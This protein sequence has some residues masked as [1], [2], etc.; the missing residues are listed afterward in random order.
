MNYKH[1]FG[2]VPSRRLG[3]SLG[4]DLVEHKTCNFNCIYCEAGTTTNLTN[5]REDYVSFE[6]IKKELDDYLCK[7]PELDYITFS[8]AGEPTLHKYLGQMISYIKEK[9][10]KYK[11][12]L[13]TNSALFG[14]EDLRNELLPLDLVLPSLDSVINENFQKINRPYKDISLEKIISG[15]T[16]FSQK[17]TG[18]IWLE[19]FILDGLNDS[20]EELVIFKQILEK[21][22]L[23]KIQLNSLDRPGTEEWVKKISYEN[24]QNIVEFLKPLP[25]EIIAKFQS[26]KIVKQIGA[27][28]SYQII[29]LV[30]RRPCTIEDIGRILDVSSQKAEKLCIELFKEGKIQ[31][32]IKDRGIFY[33]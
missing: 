25:V 28:L 15:L 29:K 17:F 22:K 8:G 10:P 6:E 3:I 23:D 16:L 26:Q 7:N 18:K 32:E 14:N 19:I 13:I 11:L 2:P 9:Y 1:L 30:K 27:D 4:V 20:T 33:K 24:M 21:M 31:K 5:T 12:A